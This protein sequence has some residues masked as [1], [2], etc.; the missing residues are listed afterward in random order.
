MTPM[1]LATLAIP[2]ILS[3]FALPR[4]PLHGQPA[5]QPQCGFG[6]WAASPG[7]PMPMAGTGSR[8]GAALPKCKRPGPAAGNGLPPKVAAEI[9]CRRKSPKQAHQVRQVYQIERGQVKNY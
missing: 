9:R 7:R 8:R 2:V 1:L 6:V 5:G 4:S 3:C